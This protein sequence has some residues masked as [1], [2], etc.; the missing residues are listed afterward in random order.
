MSVSNILCTRDFFILTCVCVHIYVVLWTLNHGDHRPQVGN[1]G[2]KSCYIKQVALL[3]IMAQIGSFIPATSARLGILDAVYTRSYYYIG[4]IFMLVL[5]IC[6]IMCR[7]GAS[8]N[9]HSGKSTF[10]VELIVCTCP[11]PAATKLNSTCYGFCHRSCTLFMFLQE[12]SE[13]M[14][15]ATSNSLVILDEL[16]RGTSTHDGTTIAYST[17]VHFIE[18]VYTGDFPTAW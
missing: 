15:L 9:I 14:R 8:D 5:P 16:G 7:M 1:M 17:L 6:V 2:G 12:A 18:Q 4:N 11:L 10:M 13:I 3:C